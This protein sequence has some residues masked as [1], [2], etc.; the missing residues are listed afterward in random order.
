MDKKVTTCD[1]GVIRK[2]RFVPTFSMALNPFVPN[3]PF[4][5]PLKISENLTVFCFQGVEKECIKKEW[6]KIIVTVIVLP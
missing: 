4:L 1:S 3:V 2:C 5:Y 6:V